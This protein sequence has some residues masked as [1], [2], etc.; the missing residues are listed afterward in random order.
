MIN[1]YFYYL[2]LKVLI[3]NVHGWK[4]QTKCTQISQS[5]LSMAAAASLP[6]SKQ[7]S[8][9]KNFD[10]FELNNNNNNNNNNL[11]DTD[12]IFNSN[13]DESKIMNLKCSNINDFLFIGLTQYGVSTK[14][15]S[16][17]QHHN[18]CQINQD[19]CL[20][21]VDYLANECNGLN[22]CDIQLDSQFLHSCKN[23]SDYLSVAY[24]CIPGAKRVDICSNE[25]LYIIDP[26]SS[27]T[28]S[29]NTNDDIISR[30][31]SFYLSSPNYPNEY[32]N[33]LNNCSCKINYVHIDTD[34]NDEN[35]KRNEN[36]EINLVFKS[37]EFDMEE[38]DNEQCNKDYLQVESF[39]DKTN[40]S[41]KSLQMCG[42]YKDFNEF[43]A[44]GNSFKLNLTTDD[45]ISRRGFLIRVSPTIETRCPLGSERF[46]NEKCVRLFNET[47]LNWHEATRSCQS[48]NGRLLTIQDFVDNLKLESFLNSKIDPSLNESFW[49]SITEV[50]ASK[51]QQHS[52]YLNIKMLNSNIE[53][54]CFT[55]N[56]NQWQQEKCIARHSYIC[57][58][59]SIPVATTNKIIKKSDNQN[60]RNKLIRVACGSSSSSLFSSSFKQSSSSSSTTTTTST[61][62]KIKSNSIKNTQI[63]FD[64]TKRRISN[65]IIKTIMTTP[66]SSKMVS[67]YEYVGDNDENTNSED[68]N[69]KNEKI[70][71]I[72]LNNLS[73]KSTI[74]P[75]TSK[76]SSSFL[77]NLDLALIIAI[78]SGA[79]VVLIAVNI[80]CVWHYYNRKLKRKFNRTLTT[81]HNTYRTSTLKPKNTIKS[82][83][84]SSAGS[85][86]IDT[87]NRTL[88]STVDSYTK[89]PQYEIL[90]QNKINEQL[91]SE[92]SSASSTLIDPSSSVLTNEFLIQNEKNI[93]FLKNYFQN[94]SNN[95]SIQISSNHYYETLS[96]KPIIKMNSSNNNYLQP[97]QYN[98]YQ[99]ISNAGNFDQ[100]VIVPA[101]QI[102][103]ANGQ[104]FLVLAA[105]P[106][107]IIQQYSNI[108]GDS[109]SPSSTSVSSNQPL[110]TFVNNNSSIN[111][112][113]NTSENSS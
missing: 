3:K 76:S 110:L 37:F 11:I 99:S 65:T 43:Y 102:E 85:H 60:N 26:S 89:V 78:V 15:T 12:D 33:N 75:T 74:E 23:H 77:F 2:K 80:F 34:N 109:V 64:A 19:D 54:K 113:N 88:T 66:T 90:N 79:S 91:S 55:K 93:E 28:Q 107:Q 22:S 62:N 38:A 49:S 112:T 21:T 4:Y 101:S 44:K 69:N 86:L 9:N 8:N 82:N 36:Q 61:T 72:L 58:F 52:S 71:S 31:G 41:I 42:Q 10:D 81:E 14:S 105:A 98:E 46:N 16:N 1:F 18:Q 92:T 25:E 100:I 20:V 48:L 95:N 103:T 32:S 94:K 108:Y 56:L 39:D 87:T 51:K 97:A 63:P 7:K 27:S 13:H 40:K 84:S 45:V 5:S 57:E 35:D 50:S 29:L 104:T 6:L 17:H 67:N 96:T 68:L 70:K 83:S 47:K 106:Q 30:F 53:K 24:E 111:N 59:N 73:K